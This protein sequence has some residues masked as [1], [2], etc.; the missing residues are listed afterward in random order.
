VHRESPTG[1]T[2]L[3]ATSTRRRRRTNTPGIQAMS[4]RSRDHATCLLRAQRRC[5][6]PNILTG[7]DSASAITAARCLRSGCGR[8]ARRRNRA[9]VPAPGKA[10]A[11]CAIPTGIGSHLHIRTAGR[12]RWH[13]SAATHRTEGASRTRPS[14]LQ[15]SER[16]MLLLPVKYT[17]HIYYIQSYA[18]SYTD[19]FVWQGQALCRIMPGVLAATTLATLPTLPHQPT[20]AAAARVPL[21]QPTAGCAGAASTPLR[22]WSRQGRGYWAAQGPRAARRASRR[23]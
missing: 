8:W 18:V 10:A 7:A 15:A 6:P 14:P 5:A 17:L 2:T 1:R 19:I 23:A 16:F 22:I 11:W 21:P 4:T 12:P 20:M 9:T 13:S 3:A